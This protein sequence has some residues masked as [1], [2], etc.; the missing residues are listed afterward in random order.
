MPPGPE[1]NAMARDAYSYLH[2]PMVAGIVAASF[3]LKEVIHHPAEALATTPALGL[4]GGLGLYLLGH[5]AFRWRV[6]GTVN[7]ERLAVGLVLF[8]LTAA[9]V[10][11]PGWA[12]LTLVL[13][14]MIGIV[15]YET[16]AWAETRDRVRHHPEMGIHGPDPDD[17]SPEGDGEAI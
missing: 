1:Q 11:V 17:G 10:A 5:V 6:A 15:G 14:V 2:F 16:V 4:C 3:G 12:S 9:A 8:A 13:A 7:R